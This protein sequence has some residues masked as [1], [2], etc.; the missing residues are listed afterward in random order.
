MY[1]QRELIRLGVHKAALRRRMA[2]RRADCV[3]SATQVFRPVAWL[4]HLLVLWRRLSP[5]AGLAAIPFGLLLKRS[6]APR[7]RLLG[8]L[9]RWAPVVWGAMR[10]LASPSR[11]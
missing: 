3:S 8:V 1:P 6:T 7:P 9:L 2:R 11:R 10:G 5:F 4:D